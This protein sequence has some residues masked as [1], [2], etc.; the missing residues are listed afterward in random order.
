MNVLV[1]LLQAVGGAEVLAVDSPQPDATIRRSP[2]MTTFV[3][4]MTTT[5]RLYTAAARVI[6]CFLLFMA[7]DM[8]PQQQNCDSCVANKRQ[9]CGRSESSGQCVRGTIE[10]KKSM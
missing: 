7:I 2:T 3:L 1:A 10:G 6:A 8:C 5:G 9:K 4:T